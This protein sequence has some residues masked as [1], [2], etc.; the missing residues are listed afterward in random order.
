MTRV[1]ISGASIAGPAL[2]V[3]LRRAG[4]EPVIIE[5]APALR[6]GG[7]NID[8][9]GAA[10]EVIRR[11]GIDDAVA[12]AT[13]G[14]EGTEFLGS[15][16]QVVAAFPAGQ[17]DSGGATGEREI[18]RGDLSEIL[19][20][21][22]LAGDRPVEY[23]F[24]DRIT[25]LTEQADGVLVAFEHAPEE[26]FDVV[27]A[28]D[29]IGSTTR[30]LV[31]GDEVVIRSLNLQITWGTIPRADDDKPWWRWYNAP[32]GRSVTLR[33][34]T[35]GTT[36]AALTRMTDGGTRAGVQDRSS[37]GLL[38][39]LRTDFADAGWQAERILGAFEEADDLYS[40]SI[41]QVFAP[42]WAQG[43]VGLLGDAA[44]CASPVSGMGT[45]LALVGAYVLAGELTSHDDHAAGFAAYE[46][47]MRPYVTQAQKL[48]PGTPRLANPRT[49][50]GIAAFHGVLR[51]GALL[52][53]WLGEKLFSPPAEAIDLPT[54]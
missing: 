52:P 26:L 39:R 1:L 43:R 21:Q 27:V 41:G 53:S 6:P 50:A 22:T 35:H 42:T 24:G 33:P 8:I 16:G 28:A 4:W 30:D 34:D 36:R 23:R 31:F 44:W 20:D 9:R 18:L 32:G 45:S 5:R 40:E 7:Q 37:A 47:V 49:R 14:E 25:G 13:T 17:T 51:V 2:A 12:A 15:D 19:V 46:R 54:Y 29:G 48:P 10:R 3:W 11:M 38:A